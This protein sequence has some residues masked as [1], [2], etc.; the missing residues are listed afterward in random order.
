MTEAEILAELPASLSTSFSP[1]NGLTLAVNV[2]TLTELGAVIL[3]LAKMRGVP[4]FP[5]APHR[6]FGGDLTGAIET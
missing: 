4:M 2:T 5:E 1:V 3:F 6:T